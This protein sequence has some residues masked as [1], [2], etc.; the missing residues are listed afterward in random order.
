MEEKKNANELI[1]RLQEIPTQK[2]RR[3]IH[4]TSRT[5]MRN[6]PTPTPPKHPTKLPL[7][8]IAAH[9][10][11]LLP[12]QLLLKLPLYSHDLRWHLQPL[13]AKSTPC[14]SLSPTPQTAPTSTSTSQ[15]TR[16]T[17]WYSSRRGKGELVE[18]G[19]PEQQKSDHLYMRCRR[20]RSLFVFPT[21]KETRAFGTAANG[22]SLYRME[23][24]ASRSLRLCM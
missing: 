10:H 22:C 3:V 16:T 6:P 23:R 4:I 9:H 21:K 8:F 5:R 7:S 11:H 14:V 20:C 19:R 18:K 12:P 2:A 17:F 13:P 15:Y 1:I 24:N